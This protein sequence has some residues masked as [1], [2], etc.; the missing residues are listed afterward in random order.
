MPSLL[1]VSGTEHNNVVC[2]ITCCT[3][4]LHD[5]KFYSDFRS[6]C[7]ILSLFSF[8]LPVAGLVLSDSVG[9]PQ[10]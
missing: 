4:V 5:L 1:A 3:V 2:F 6:G 10:A 7:L 9:Q 8:F